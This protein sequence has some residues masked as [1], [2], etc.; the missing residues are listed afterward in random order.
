MR[1]FILFV[2]Q[3]LK[4][5]GTLLLACGYF[6]LISICAR[7]IPQAWS[8]SAIWSSGRSIRPIPNHLRWCMS[9]AAALILGVHIANMVQWTRATNLQSAA[10]LLVRVLMNYK[11]ECRSFEEASE[12]SIRVLIFYIY[13]GNYTAR[14]EGLSWGCE[15]SGAKRSEHRNST[16]YMY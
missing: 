9:M 2:V 6:G 8:I 10:L 15:R 13:I 14:P 1:K 3:K 7:T 11:L 4:V 5:L 16:Y 12:A